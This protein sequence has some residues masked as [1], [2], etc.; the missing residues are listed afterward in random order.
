METFAE[1]RSAPAT[2]GFRGLLLE[3]TTRWAAGRHPGGQS[4]RG[5][6]SPLSP[7][8]ETIP[9]AD[10]GRDA[11]YPAPLRRPVRALVSAHGSC[12]C[13]GGGCRNT[14]AQPPC[15]RT[16]FAGWRPLASTARGALVCGYWRAILPLGWLSGIGLS[17]TEEVRT[18]PRR[19]RPDGLEHGF[20]LEP[21]VL[22]QAPREGSRDR[23][24]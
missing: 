17:R 19:E 20:F 15:G 22:P 11:G 24:G 13:M 16:G 2:G 9:G 10:R 23:R 6:Y 18:L 12:T 8:V 3:A 1:G 21:T 4:R 14:P 7:C 5:P